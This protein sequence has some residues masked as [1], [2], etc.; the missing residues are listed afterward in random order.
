V[1]RI[2]CLIRILRK[3][4]KQ[5]VKIM[6]DLSKL[7]AAVADLAAKVDAMNAKPQPV[8]D[9]PAIDALTDQVTAI[10]AKIP[11]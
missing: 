8:S 1:S 7:T 10:A 11:A 4:L 2:I 3:I 9:Q 6:N 5:Q